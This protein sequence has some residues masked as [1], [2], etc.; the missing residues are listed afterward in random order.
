MSRDPVNRDPLNRDRRATLRL[1]GGL[2]LLG[3]CAGGGVPGG[4]ARLR[5]VMLLPLNGA[6]AGLGQSMAQAARLAQPD[7]D[8]LIELDIRDTGGTA[9]G[10]AAAVQGSG[11]RLVLGPVFA[12]E[13]PGVLAAVG[14]GVP[15]LTLSNDASLAARGAVVF[16]LTQ[17]Q[18]IGPI[19]AYAR[20]QGVR[21][22]GLI[23]SPGPLGAQSLAATQAAAAR[24]GLDL[25][26]TL[27]APDAPPI[28]GALA[29][30]LAAA[31]RDGRLPEAVLLPDG[32]PGLPAL[33]RGL[34]GA[35][36]QLL[37]TAQWLGT[38]IGAEPA[39]SGAW[40]AAPDPTGFAPF[41][42]RMAAGGASAGVL[43]ALAHDAVAVARAWAADGATD[44][45]AD[46]AADGATGRAG[47]AR[48]QGFAG[49]LGTTRCGTDG[50]CQ[51]DLAI[52]LIDQ[53][54]VRLIGRT[55]AA[56]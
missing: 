38:D 35:G 24:H 9:P 44:G 21:R 39:L 14:P 55:A 20:G 23:A 43:A 29:D 49:A 33:A 27:E 16:G 30:R 17:A 25:I 31:S 47:L 45:A 8:P 7:P 22:L 34:G 52:H 46:G 42:D 40:Y 5:V 41:A 3:G 13:V 10:A 32:G 48:P 11:A 51:R 18:S 53:G 15:V 56:T 26:A 54:R 36:V 19:L 1:L 2:A 37:G 12:A 28:P 50:L 6:R 4:P